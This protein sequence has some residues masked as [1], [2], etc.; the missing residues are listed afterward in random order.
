M[1]WLVTGKG[2]EENCDLARLKQALR[3]KQGPLWLDIEAPKPADF[4]LLRDGFGIHR[5]TIEDIQQGGQRP[6]WE[7]YPGYVFL[8]LV[9]LEWKKQ[10]AVLQ[11]Q[12]LCISPRWIISLHQKPNPGLA[13][14]RRRLE[15]DPALAQGR[16]MFVTYLV[17]GAIVDSAFPALE[18][19]DEEVDALED[20]LVTTATQRDLPRITRL[21]HSVTDLRRILG[22]QRD[23]FQRLVTQSL[24]PAAPEA[25]LYFR[26]IYDHLVRQYETV[27]SLRDLLS[28]A[29][30]TYLSTVS[31]RLNGTMKTL[32]VMASLF[33]PLTFL[34][35]FFGMNF[36]YLI[37]VLEPSGL[38]FIGAI[39][40]MVLSLVLQLYLFRRRN[41]I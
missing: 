2:Q 6:K 41:W 22:A 24:D 28:G 26:D 8:V 3:A 21:K 20:R 29:M 36:A 11:E 4:E 15:V 39:V 10:A 30:D 12:Y 19:I 14:V 32:T 31:N 13:E 23:S 25:S 27:D 18:G 35:G 38:A 5:L 40:L 34:T 9:A 17:T 7:D 1:H 16:P 37:R 33:L